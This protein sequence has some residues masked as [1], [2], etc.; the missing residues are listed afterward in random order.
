MSKLSNY[1]VAHIHQVIC[2]AGTL[3][4]A[5]RNLKLT[6]NTILTSH[7]GRFLLHGE[8]L[9]V[10]SFKALSVDDARKFWGEAYTQK[11]ASPNIDIN[12]YSASHI[13]D[14]ARKT[15]TIRNLASLLGVRDH[16]V[17]RYL[18]KFNIK[19]EV[20]TF[21]RLKSLSHAAARQVFQEKYE[22][23][24][25]E[26]RVNLTPDFLKPS[27]ERRA[28]LQTDNYDTFNILAP[29]FKQQF[30]LSHALGL[31]VCVGKKR[32]MYQL[33][34]ESCLPSGM[35]DDERSDEP[36]DEPDER[37]LKK[38]READSDWFVKR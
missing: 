5:T 37:P 28:E 11:L 35:I 6:D 1:T 22:A 32:N 33:F 12:R 18:N 34:S 24:Y 9:T 25:P 26:Q 30:P 27:I 4:I 21:E 7:L 19:G 31:D 2:K 38:N 8:P 3:S 16:T 29:I 20:L 10:D 23:I 14:L 36:D 15:N 17:Q 13:H